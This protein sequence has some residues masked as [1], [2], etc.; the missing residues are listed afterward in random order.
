MTNNILNDF[1]FIK[2]LK[3]SKIEGNK[4][5]LPFI[6]YNSNYYVITSILTVISSCLYILLS[7]GCFV[8]VL[9]F[10]DLYREFFVKN[11]ILVYLLIL[12]VFIISPFVL[13]FVL[14]KLFSSYKVIDFEKGSLYTKQQIMGATSTFDFIKFEDI[15]IICNNVLPQDTLPFIKGKK[16]IYKK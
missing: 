14:S 9:K 15:T 7:L 3:G 11:I 13:V 4:I 8:G 5:Y 1:S 10:I 16:K 2:E 12:S 6:D